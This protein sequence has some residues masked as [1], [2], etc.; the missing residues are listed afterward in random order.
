MNTHLES[1]WS[2]VKTIKLCPRFQKCSVPSCPLDP[3]QGNRTVLKGEPKCT[4]AKSIRLRLG[5]SAGL[6]RKGLT[7]KEWAAK[8]RW[9]KLSEVD[10]QSR[11]ANLR[12]NLMIYTGLSDATTI[13]RV[14]S[15]GVLNRLNK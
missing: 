10:R 9:Q 2:S 14:K 7:R 5:K 13:S 4:L 6:P 8:K 3:N 1:E 12:K 15:R 11:I